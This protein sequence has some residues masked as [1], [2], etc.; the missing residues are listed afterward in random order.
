MYTNLAPSVQINNIS[1]ELNPLYNVKWY[2]QIIE[3]TVSKK[4]G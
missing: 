4:L 2:S 3:V 1:H